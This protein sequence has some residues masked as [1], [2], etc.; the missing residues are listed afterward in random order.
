M[1][2]EPL[3]EILLSSRPPLK[4]GHQTLLKDTEELHFLGSEFDAVKEKL[5]H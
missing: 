3:D 2:L 4:N 1:T 5:M